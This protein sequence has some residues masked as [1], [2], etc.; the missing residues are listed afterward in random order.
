MCCSVSREYKVGDVLSVLEPHK[1]TLIEDAMLMSMTTEMKVYTLKLDYLAGGSRRR[2]LHDPA[3]IAHARSMKT[4]LNGSPRAAHI[5][6]TWAVRYEVEVVDVQQSQ[7]GPKPA[8]TLTLEA[9]HG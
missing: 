5:M 9:H 2:R 6:P 7:F 1:I 3:N 4:L 8:W